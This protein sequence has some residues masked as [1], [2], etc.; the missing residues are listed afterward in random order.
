LSQKRSKP[1]TAKGLAALC[2]KLA[3]EII[4]SYIYIM[5][6][7]SIESSPADYFVVCSAESDIQARAIAE[8]IVLEC[9]HTGLQTPKV[10]GTE[11]AQWILLDFFDV[12]V[13]VMLKETRNFYKLESLWGDSKFYQLSG[14][15]RIKPIKKNDLFKQSEAE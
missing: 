15:G 7:T 1:R 4:A 11:N 5:D 6:L 13:H 2:A 9:K 3:D 8:H 12:V 14:K 10:E